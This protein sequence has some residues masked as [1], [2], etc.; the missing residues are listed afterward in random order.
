MRP[1]RS[2]E[3]DNSQCTEYSARIGHVDCLAAESLACL[4]L[5]VTARA[6]LGSVVRL[7][8][9]LAKEIFIKAV[10]VISLFAIKK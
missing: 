8:R 6:A 10:H 4:K 3:K 9:S 5:P 7:G 2:L 1:L